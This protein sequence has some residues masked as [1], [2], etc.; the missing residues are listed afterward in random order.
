[1]SSSICTQASK[2]HKQGIDQWLE[3][4]EEYHDH[5]LN[6]LPPIYMDACSFMNSEPYY[7]LDTGEGVYTCCKKS[8][9]KFFL[10]LMTKKEYL[11]KFRNR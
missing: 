8:D 7:H 9:G 5:L 10:K 2:N 6:C 1:M 3:I 11:K 4:D